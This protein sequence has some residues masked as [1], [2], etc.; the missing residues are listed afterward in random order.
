MVWSFIFD[1]LKYA[2]ACNVLR[3]THLQLNNTPRKPSG[4]NSSA[5]IPRWNAKLHGL[6]MCVMF[7]YYERDLGK[8]W[9]L[10]PWKHM[11]I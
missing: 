5:V 6:M 9:T 11:N 4:C 7:S 3:K 2:I 10:Y 8:S 1:I